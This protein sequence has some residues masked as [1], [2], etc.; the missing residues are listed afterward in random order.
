VPTKLHSSLN[1]T[2]RK[3]LTFI[4]P[5]RRGRWVALIGLALLVSGLEAFGALLIFVLLG[6]VTQPEQPIDLPIVG[7]F[8]LLFPELSESQFLIGLSIFVGLFFLARGLIYLTQSYLQNRIA[9]NA[10]VLLS[11]KL[12]KGYLLMPYPLHLRRNSAELIRNAHDAVS[13]V[14]SSVFLPVV[15]LISE[16][17]LVLGILAVLVFKAPT[18]TA[19]TVGLLGPLVLVILRGLQPQLARLGRVGQEATR[20]SIQSLQESLGA[21]RDIKVLG[22]EDFFSRR[23]F[24]S[25]GTLA[26]TFYLRTV[27]M[28]APRVIVET[29]LVFFILAFLVLRVNQ[30]TSAQ[31]GLALLGLFAYSVL[32]MLPSLNR[33]VTALNNLRFSRAAVNDIYEDVIFTDQLEK[34]RAEKSLEPLPFE[35]KIVLEGVSFTHAGSATETLCEIDLEISAGE[36]IGIVGETGSGKSTLIDLIL[37]LLAPSRGCMRVDEA[38]VSN[39][40]EAWQMNLGFVPQSI[41]LVDGSLRR[42]I[43]LGYEDHEI[44]DKRLIRAIEI[45]QLSEFVRRSS[46][47]LETFVG[48]QGSRLSGGQRQRVAIARAL[49]RDPKVL[50]FDE[51]TSALDNQTE[52]ALV[53]ELKSLRRAR[54]LIMVAHRLSSITWCDRV[55]V[56]R[57]GCVIADGPFNH[58]VGKYPE[59]AQGARIPSE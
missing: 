29:S 15:T 41:F 28:D 27:L 39:S 11:T 16:V 32:R 44:D 20:S 37:G 24:E 36:S 50:V 43:A 40:T 10:G 38:D 59:L 23:Y 3:A 45:A 1:S 34:S 33:I 58:L 56:L 30:T 55:I 48:E 14:I 7:D 13:S 26:R 18:V 51:G 31:G 49:Y 8:R 17:F 47:G 53:E 46:D 5:N 21:I 52:E 25:R 57:Q 42:N 9:H 35:Q 2:F 4:E 19:I 12:L 6:I 54:T 22:R